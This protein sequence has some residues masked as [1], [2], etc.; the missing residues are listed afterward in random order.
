[1]DPQDIKTLMEDLRSIK[2][3]IRKHDRLFRELLMPRYFAPLSVYMGLSLIALMTT[4]QLLALRAGSYAGIPPLVRTLLWCFLGF[5]GLS[6]SAMKWSSLAAASRRITKDGTVGRIFREFFVDP[7]GH[8]YLGIVLAS[9]LLSLFL[10]LRGDVHLVLPLLSVMIGIVWNLMGGMAGCR[11][12]LLVGYW[13]VLSGSG[14]FFV[15][16]RLPFLVP[17]WTFGL[18]FVVFGVLGLRDRAGG[19]GDRP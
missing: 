19:D 2:G 18:G 9:T 7:I 5:I 3:A 8:V 10:G 15:A 14:S 4:F 11:E 16:H 1:M 13:L 12:Y 6:S 17:A